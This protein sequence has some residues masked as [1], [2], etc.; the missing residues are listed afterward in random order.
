MSPRAKISLA[1]LASLLALVNAPG[2]AAERANPVPPVV[3]GA[4]PYLDVREGL[5]VAKASGAR[6][7][8][9]FRR[10]FGRGALLALDRRTGT[11][12]SGMR[13]GG[14]L[15][16][17]S[18]RDPRTV[19]RDFVRRHAAEIG[20]SAADVDGLGRPRVV[21]A[22][23]GL[24]LLRFPQ[25]VA[26]VPS[27]DSEV[28]VAVDRFGRVVTVGGSPASGLRASSTDPSVGPGRALRRVAASVGAPTAPRIIDGPRGARH[29]TR[30]ASGDMARL[31][32]FE[33]GTGP[34]RLAWHTTFRSGPR[35]FYDAVVDAASGRI[36]RRRELSSAAAPA[37]VWQLNP[38]AQRG[39]QQLAVDLEA[40]GWLAP[41]AQRLIGPN[42]H[43]FA[44]VDANDRAR[45]SEEIRRTAQGT[46]EFPYQP[47]SPPSPV[48]EG[49]ARCFA[50]RLCG[51]NSD[52]PRS[53]R[54]N[55]NQT[56]T[57]LFYYVNVFHDYLE[58]P[59]IGFDRASGNFEGDDAVLAAADY[60][61]A[62]GK[63]GGPSAG[64]LNNAA[65]ATG[66]D[67]VAPLMTM[68][69]AAHNSAP[70]AD[71]DAVEPWTFY[72]ASSAD[73][74]RTVYHEYTHGLTA[75][76]VT[77]ADGSNAM[78]GWQGLAMTEA[79]ADWYAAD[80][81]AYQGLTPD[82]PSVA[83]ELDFGA[84][85]ESRRNWNR[86]EPMD[87]PVGQRGGLC[88][89]SDEL[90]PGVGGFTFAD[91]GDIN[92]RVDS[93]R[94]LEYFH[95][96]GEIW[97]ETLWDLR[98]EL[99]AQAGP[100]EGH[101]LAVALVTTGL[102]LTQPEP[103]FVD[104]RNAIIQADTAL[105]GG[106]YNSLIWR[107]FAHRG[108]GYYASARDTNDLW[109]VASFSLPPG[110]E[111]PRG[112]LRGRITDVDTGRP[113]EGVRVSV[114]GLGAQVSGS[115]EAVTDA[116][117]G[118]ELAL[119][120]RRYRR[121]EI[122]GPTGYL[123][124]DLGS[125]TIAADQAT[126]GNARIRRSWAVTGRITSTPVGSGPLASVCSS[127]AIIDGDR[128]SAW[129]ESVS[130]RRASRPIA[131]LKLARPVDVTAY[132]IDPR[133]GCQA[134]SGAATKKFKLESSRD[135]RRWKTETTRTL[136]LFNRFAVVRPSGGSR[137]VRYVRLTLL[138]PR[139]WSGGEISLSE[140]AVFGIAR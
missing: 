68:Y 3:P 40:P 26:G 85:S 97:S 100:A 87:C 41:G 134:S 67:G 103:T 64:Y 52:N 59:P 132:A 137:R 80:L 57:Q 89:G 109:P 118:Y 76:L 128:S 45:S 106:R 2:A 65:M 25:A 12:R 32:L 62:T 43:A 129:Y 23:G 125:V 18:G 47:F 77:T 99:V 78:T 98:S 35:G 15:T 84:G 19:A 136:R 127:K 69:L 105:F 121:V 38:G 13:L 54:V 71:A 9:A 95:A 56:T 123:R 39:G 107:V 70:Y 74:A 58:A 28:T 24:T 21:R 36:L 51:W 82:D 7:R 104:A 117:G 10:S 63:N 138:T 135:G 1:S 27:F 53:W 66:P 120:A 73:D 96:E 48:F 93:G 113:V 16:A 101:T 112:T 83:G 37:S 55:R 86:E 50:P 11:V 30:F 81:L 17:T 122:Q 94:G 133:P 110:P 4:A 42:A 115:T 124:R 91:F 5:P 139:K 8:A 61:A 108:M 14:T 131:V 29:V 88:D 46:F 31:V 126:A 111:T 22:P 116:T 130:G 20:L 79:W 114:A 49:R 60:G 119:P 92:G 140:L 44:D 75:R 33:L 90:R 6:A 72:D 34:A 102:R